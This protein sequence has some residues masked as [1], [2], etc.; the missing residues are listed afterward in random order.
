M[1]NKMNL[2]LFGTK[3]GTE[4]KIYPCVF[5]LVYHTWPTD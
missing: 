5:L 1:G 4:V 2:R 3:A